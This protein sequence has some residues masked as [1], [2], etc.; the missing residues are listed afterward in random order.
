MI[1][2][3]NV[4]YKASILCMLCTVFSAFTISLAQ[5]V[6]FSKPTKFSVETSTAVK[7]IQSQLLTATSDGGALTCGI[8]S[9]NRHAISKLSPSGDTEWE[10]PLNADTGV[11][12]STMTEVSGKNYLITGYTTLEID[13]LIIFYEKYA[14]LLDKNGNFVW[15][16]PKDTSAPNKRYFNT[17]N[18]FIKCANKRYAVLTNNG[19]N[20]FTYKTRPILRFYNEDGILIQEAPQDSLHTVSMFVRSFF[21][22]KDGGFGALIHT[23]L[24]TATSQQFWRFDSSGVLL[25]KQVWADV[26]YSYDSYYSSAIETKDSTIVVAT[27][28]PISDTTYVIMRRF[29]SSGELQF[30]RQYAVRDYNSVNQ[31]VETPNQDIV[32][33]GSSYDK[34][35][36]AIHPYTSSDICLIRTD[37]SGN[38][39]WQETFGD[40]TT[41]DFGV[42]IGVVDEHTL[43]LSCQTGKAEEFTTAFKLVAFKISDAVTR[44][45][46]GE[47]SK[48]THSL[49]ISPQPTNT[50]ATLT[51]TTDSPVNIS[52]RITNLLG[53]E[54][55]PPIQYQTQIGTNTLHLPTVELANGM[56]IISINS[57]NG[58]TS[59]KLIIAH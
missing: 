23:R 6:N 27:T 14:A 18:P 39:K 24:D 20:V 5:P 47:V 45:D 43:Y 53:V 58:I 7:G 52:L 34:F 31:V 51:F 50:E 55:L 57:D 28:A 2:F 37:Y 59:Q 29:S 25:W 21:Q 40:S 32:M 49:T 38:V 9:F 54:V 16:M 19:V 13:S 30:R 11:V 48:S 42:S 15:K 3:D 22:T 26:P 41:S 8:V 46:E 36:Q 56:Y 10:K 17:S 44:V 12:I 1:T 33:I 4:Y 35:Q